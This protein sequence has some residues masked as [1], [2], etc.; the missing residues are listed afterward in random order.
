MG[1]QESVEKSLEEISRFFE[2][3][4]SFSKSVMVDTNTGEVNFGEWE[5]IIPP[6]EL[7]KHNSP[8]GRVPGVAITGLE[9]GALPRNWGEALTEFM[10][11][12]SLE[13]LRQNMTPATLLEPVYALGIYLKAMQDGGVIKDYIIHFDEANSTHLSGAIGYICRIQPADDREHSD[14]W[15]RRCWETFIAFL[16][17]PRVAARLAELIRE[18][19]PQAVPWAKDAAELAKELSKLLT[20]KGLLNEPPLA[21]PV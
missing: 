8:H 14:S 1:F 21:R 2:S 6:A 15:W 7:A 13:A 17:E 4:P 19:G 10:V 20:D 18:A 9:E 11:D 5:S 16:R 3:A 12:Y